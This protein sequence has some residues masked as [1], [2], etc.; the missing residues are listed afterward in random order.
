[1]TRLEDFLMA[2]YSSLNNSLSESEELGNTRLNY[3]LTLTT[4]IIGGSGIAKILSPTTQGTDLTLVLGLFTLFF[5]GLVTFS[6][7]IHRNIITDSYKRRLNTI[8]EYFVRNDETILNYL[9]YNPITY[10]EARGD[11]WPKFYSVGSGGLV[12]T[13]ALLNSFILVSILGIFLS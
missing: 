6:R 2:E 10:S 12:Q 9:P 4:A 11:K 5:Y 8:R 3:F 1:M 7:L 13:A